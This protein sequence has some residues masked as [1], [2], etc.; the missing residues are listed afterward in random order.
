L[1]A[2]WRGIYNI[3]RK[4]RKQFWKE[5]QAI[6]K[7]DRRYDVGYRVEGYNDVE[8]HELIPDDEKMLKIY[9]IKGIIYVVFGVL[10]GV[11]Q[12]IALHS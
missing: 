3:V 6:K 12:L 10:A 5:N 2:L 7:L 1:I 8:K 9:K 11:F 4:T